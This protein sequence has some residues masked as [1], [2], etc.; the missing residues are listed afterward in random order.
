[1]KA[2]Y[3]NLEI[4]ANHFNRRLQRMARHL[5]IDQ[6]ALSDLLIVQCRGKQI[7]VDHVIHTAKANQA[8]VI[9]IDPAYKLFGWDEKDVS[10]WLRNF[11]LIVEATNALLIVIHHEKKGVAGDRQAVDRGAGDGK[12]SRDYDCALQ[13]APQRDEPDTCIVLSQVQRNYAP[14]DAVVMRFESGAFEETDLPPI[15]ATSQSL[16]AGA[17]KKEPSNDAI[18]RLIQ[19]HGPYSKTELREILIREGC[20]TRSAPAYIDALAR[21]TPEVVIHK[22]RKPG[23]RTMVCTLSQRAEMEGEK[24]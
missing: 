1:M 7:D 10:I 6:A 22:E 20:T 21:I 17:G 16:R 23:G 18:I 13:I 4:R 3:F 5:D 24:A 12:M 8:D 9:I 2:V 15:E 14:A 11:D 19:D